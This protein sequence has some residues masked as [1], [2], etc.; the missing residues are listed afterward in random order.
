M[1]EQGATLHAWLVAFHLLML[2]LML[3]ERDQLKA[4]ARDEAAA[5]EARKNK[6]TV[7]VDLL[8]R[9][10]TCSCLV[11]HTR[12]GTPLPCYQL[13]WFACGQAVFAHTDT[14]PV[15]KSHVRSLA[16]A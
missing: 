7:T 11:T 9:Q 12:F 16:L 8:G 13:Y 3:Q 6:V 15:Y 1:W 2:I 10:V 4:R 14:P 5:L